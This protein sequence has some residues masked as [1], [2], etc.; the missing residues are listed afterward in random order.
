MNDC[1]SLLSCISDL[2]ACLCTPCIDFQR[3][4]EISHSLPHT[5]SQIFFRKIGLPIKCPFWL[6]VSC[7]YF[8]S[9]M[10]S[11]SVINACIYVIPKRHSEGIGTSFAKGYKSF[12]K[13]I[14]IFFPPYGVC[15]L[16][17]MT[18]KCHCFSRGFDDRDDWFCDVFGSQLFVIFQFY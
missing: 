7:F 6:K 15:I 9:F 12:C 2:Y 3:F 10:L 4:L 17:C 11:L 14:A 1:S 8:N 13:D 5:C 16:V 18:K